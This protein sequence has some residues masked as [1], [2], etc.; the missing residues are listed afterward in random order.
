M[1][2]GHWDRAGRATYLSE[3]LH[4]ADE[5][6]AHEDPGDDEREQEEPVDAAEVVDAV[7][8]LQHRLPARPKPNEHVR[9]HST[10]TARRR[11]GG[12]GGGGGGGGG[13]TRR[14]LRGRRLVPE[15][16]LGGPRRVALGPAELREREGRDEEE[17]A[18]GADDDVVP[19]V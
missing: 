9:M 1:R 8:L 19:G 5:R 7:R 10:A 3:R 6:A 2:R 18:L 17:D 12:R 4:A 13:R 15:A 11:G 16:A 14:L